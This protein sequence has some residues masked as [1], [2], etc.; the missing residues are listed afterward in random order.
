LSYYLV[1]NKSRLFGFILVQLRGDLLVWR[2]L[3]FIHFYSS[4]TTRRSSCCAH[5]FSIS[6]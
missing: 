5:I 2:L 4:R 1:N 3:V 6:M